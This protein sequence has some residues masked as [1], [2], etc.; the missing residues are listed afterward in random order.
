MN[1]KQYMEKLKAVL[2][3]FEQELQEEIIS[4]Y[5]EHYEIGL[6]MGKTEEQISEEL[7]DIDELVKELKKIEP[8]KEEATAKGKGVSLDKNSVTE[9]DT[10]DGTESGTEANAG[11]GKGASSKENRHANSDKSFQNKKQ[12]NKGPQRVIL[13]SKFAMVWVTK[14][15]DGR[16]HLDWANHS[17]S[18]AKDTYEFNSWMKGDTIYGEVVKKSGGFIFGRGGDI[19][20]T[21]AIPDNFPQLDIHTMSGDVNV[22]DVNM[23]SLVIYAASA[24]FRIRNG[25]FYQ[26]CLDTKSGSIEM[27]QVQAG[28]MRIDSKSGDLFLHGLQ[29]DRICAKTLSGDV[30]VSS[31][32][33]NICEFGTVSGDVSADS[34]Q[35]ER[36]HVG[37]LSG[38]I[39]VFRSQ[40]GQ[41]SL[42]SKSGD[43]SAEVMFKQ[44]QALSIS[45]DV[46]VR[47]AC[48]SDVLMSSVSG[49]ISLSLRNIT[50]Y[51][52]NLRSVSGVKKCSFSATNSFVS[53]CGNGRITF[54]TGSSKIDAKTTSG[55]IEIEA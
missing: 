45:G 19:Q 20:L 23:Q 11:L 18:N 10:K 13:K 3:C 54:G 43:L 44:V 50:G 35:A 38:D 22:D 12:D 39:K 41:M 30:R 49:D 40:G 33:G 29:V 26:L 42:D 17:Q 8:R 34:N 21:V 7:G 52:A 47:N 25:A 4:D 2:Q 27:N 28:N 53:Q 16:I 15:K 55:D 14:S 6:Q 37:S 46:E 51:T 36:F 31:L 32:H 9:T 1:R 48:E 24:N 5:E